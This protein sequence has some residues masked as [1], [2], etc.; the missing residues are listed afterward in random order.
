[1]YLPPRI[2][3]GSGLF[4]EWVAWIALAAV[5]GMLLYALI[6]IFLDRDRRSIVGSQLEEE[7]P[8]HLAAD[9]VEA[10]PFQIDAKEPPS[11]L[12][13]EAQR[14]YA[15][16]N[17]DQAIVYLYSFQLVELDKQH[18][19]HLTRGKTNR[20]YLRE[21]QRKS[22]LGDLLQSTM[23]AFE[24]VFFGKHPLSRLRFEQ[25]W[26]GVDEFQTRLRREVSS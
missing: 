19:I 22:Q 6:R 1:M 8:L 16:G 20:Q 24:D 9:K 26:S 17:Y 21:T 5:I 7:Q 4:L 3:P 18:V 13:A 2:C 23:V 12:L 25:C 10:L 15:A 11:D 14:Q